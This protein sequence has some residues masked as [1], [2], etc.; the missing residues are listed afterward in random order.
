MGGGNEDAAKV[1]GEPKRGGKA[2]RKEAVRMPG[3]VLTTSEIL[4]KK[5][6]RVLLSS[7][8]KDFY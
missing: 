1:K 2:K 6:C 4:C 8:K 3:V 7:N 5:I